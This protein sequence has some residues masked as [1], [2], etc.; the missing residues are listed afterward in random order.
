MHIASTLLTNNLRYWFFYVIWLWYYQFELYPL[1]LAKK[2]LAF[3]AWEAQDEYL[4]FISK[5]KDRNV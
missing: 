3:T 5:S 4:S 1:V 2:S